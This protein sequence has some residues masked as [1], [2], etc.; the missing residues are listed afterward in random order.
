MEDVIFRVIAVC[1]VALCFGGFLLWRGITGDVWRSRFTGEAIVPAW[2]YIA[3]GV[4]T[5]VG[6]IGYVVVTLLLATN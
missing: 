6:T 5:M 2:L 1:V 3:G 4:L